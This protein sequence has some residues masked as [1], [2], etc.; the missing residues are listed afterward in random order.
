MASRFLKINRA[1]YAHIITMSSI[2]CFQP[3]INHNMHTDKREIEELDDS[4]LKCK[5]PRKLI[6]PVFFVFTS[7]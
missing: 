5:P 4:A 2:V 6:S 7:A 3:E 1:M